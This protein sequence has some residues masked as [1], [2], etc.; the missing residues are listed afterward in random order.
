MVPVPETSSV[1]AASV[2]HSLNKPY[3]R[4]FVRNTYVFRTFIMSG[5]EN[6]MNGVRRKINTIR[7]EFIDRVV[8]LID[9]SIVQGTTCR[10]LVGMAREAG[11]KRVYRERLSG[12]YVSPAL[13]AY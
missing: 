12:S 6:R 9:D 4:A 11:A 5:Q 3:C 1:A 2:A 7:E 10:E 8:L 13:M